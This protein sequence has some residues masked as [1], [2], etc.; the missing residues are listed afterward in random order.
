M[1]EDLPRQV[2]R[3]KRFTVGEPHDPT[4][5]AEGRL[6]AYLCAGELRVCDVA[7]ESGSGTNFVTLAVC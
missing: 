2:A 1:I 3:T 5:V 4:I 6:V 7:A